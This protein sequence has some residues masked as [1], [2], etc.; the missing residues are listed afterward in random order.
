VRVDDID[1]RIHCLLL[2]C[3]DVSFDGRVAQSIH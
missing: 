3:R 2:D 1:A